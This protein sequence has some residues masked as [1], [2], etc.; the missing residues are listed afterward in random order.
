MKKTIFILMTA[1]LAASCMEECPQQ[2]LPSSDALV[3]SAQQVAVTSGTKAPVTGTTFPTSLGMVLA[4]YSSA[5]SS[6][7]FSGIPFSYSS[8]DGGWKASTAKYWPQSGTVDFFAYSCPGLS[9][10]VTYQS[11]ASAGVSSFVTGSNASAQADLMFGAASGCTYSSNSKP[12]LNFKHAMAL[13]SF[14]VRCPDMN[15]SSGNGVTIESI[16]MGNAYWGGTCSA[17]RSGSNV[18]SISWSSLS[19]QQNGVALQGTSSQGLT[20]TAAAYGNG[21]LLP[22]QTAVNFTINQNIILTTSSYFHAAQTTLQICTLE[23]GILVTNVISQILL[24]F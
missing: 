14:T 15:Y 4:A 6:T 10:T 17:S 2:A 18:N 20:T 22:P 21:F 7:Y 5:S 13:V 19:N 24:V 23:F 16:T 12:Q 11:N 1:L 3:L 9:P 8:G